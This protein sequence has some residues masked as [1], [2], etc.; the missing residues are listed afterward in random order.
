MIYFDNAATTQP[1]PEVIEKVKEGL[2]DYGNPSSSHALGKRTKIK[3]EE[4]RENVASLINCKPENIVFTSGGTESNNWAIYSQIANSTKKNMIT[5][6]I[7]HHSILKASEN[8]TK[9]FNST[10]I[11]APV[12]SNGIVSLGNLLRD[13]DINSN[14]SLVSIMYANNETGA[15]QPIKEIVKICKKNNILMHTDAVQAVGKIPVD[16]QELEIDLLSLS[17]HKFH[18]P[19]GV[20]ALYVKDGVRID[21]MVS[22]GHQ[23][24]GLRAGTY[25]VPAIMGMGEAARITKEKMLDFTALSAEMY[26]YQKLK[27]R[28]LNIYRVSQNSNRIPGIVNV[29]IPG[30]ESKL[31]VIKASEKGL[32]CSSGSACNE[33]NTKPSHVLTAMGIDPFEAHSSIRFSLDSFCTISEVD[34][35][36]EIIVDVLKDMHTI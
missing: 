30:V 6:S 19:K 12:D 35:S 25:N 26:F 9:T 36:I 5:S 10:A 15:I 20:G 29:I 24:N 17:G 18:G 3:V 22:G 2:L 21:P 28:T 33:G 27:E 1:Y 16:I 14:I 34:A 32:C 4:A 31:F 8:I 23:E 11:Y 13:I 7:E